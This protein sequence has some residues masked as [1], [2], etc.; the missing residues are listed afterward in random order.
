M[1]SGTA[2]LNPLVLF[3]RELRDDV[4]DSLKEVFQECSSTHSFQSTKS[5]P[6]NISVFEQFC[7]NIYIPYVPALH[8]PGWL[9]RYAVGPFNQNWVERLMGDL[10]SGLTVAFLLIPQV[11][12][13]NLN[14]EYFYEHALT[15]K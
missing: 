4:Y 11:Y 8:S 6:S 7:S 2:R 12:Y 10:V 14:N 1:G 15:N 5:R 13:E 9:L 3:A